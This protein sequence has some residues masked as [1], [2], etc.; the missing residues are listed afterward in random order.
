MT[1]EAEDKC[2]HWPPQVM[3]VRRRWAGT[4]AHEVLRDNDL[5]LEIDGQRIETFRDIEVAVSGRERV[6][7]LIVRGGEKLHVCVPTTPLV[8]STTDRIVLWC[9][10]VLQAPTL[11]VAAQRGQPRCGVYVSSRFHGSPAAKYN[12]PPMARIIEVDGENVP[13]LDALLQV[14]AAKRDGGDVRIK[15]LDLRGAPSMTC[16]RI[17]TKYWPTA[18]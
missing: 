4:G 16:L 2:E 14:I 7:L 3:C 8:D 11:A 12:L 13:G 15:H 17:D 5:L 9:G 18:E 1:E 10:A 6:T